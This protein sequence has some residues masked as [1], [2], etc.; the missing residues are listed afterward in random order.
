MN[1]LAHLLIMDGHYNMKPLLI[2]LTNGILLILKIRN[3]F[4]M[5]QMQRKDHHTQLSFGRFKIP[6]PLLSEK[7]A[8]LA[9]I[10]P[11]RAKKLTSINLF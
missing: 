11:I 6:I 3:N 9:S 5:S 2:F 8:Y 7:M 10:I 1:V 4:K